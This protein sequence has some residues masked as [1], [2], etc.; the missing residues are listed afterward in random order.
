MH[1]FV[2]VGLEKNVPSKRRKYFF[3]IRVENVYT[4]TWERMYMV[5]FEIR[6]EARPSRKS[7]LCD[8]LGLGC[9]RQHT[10]IIQILEACVRLP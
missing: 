7:L 3:M 1:Q 8:V 9:R 4:T 2:V 6:G 10:S 5:H